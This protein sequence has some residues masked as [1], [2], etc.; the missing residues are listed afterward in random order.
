VSEIS[1][2]LRAG[3]P[4][5]HPEFVRSVQAAKRTGP[6]DGV[7]PSWRLPERYDK[8]G[9]VDV[10]QLRPLKGDFEV[11]WN[12]TEEAGDDRHPA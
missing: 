10:T 1:R 5:H 8:Q 11:M 7:V 3:H 6:T 9:Y 4:P 12:E 2:I